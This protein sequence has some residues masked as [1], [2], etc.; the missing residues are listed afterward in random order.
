MKD[1]LFLAFFLILPN[2]IFAYDTTL[3]STCIGN[4]TSGCSLCSNSTCSRCQ[5]GYT[6]NSGSN[7]CSSNAC[8]I[9]NCAACSIN[10][11]Y[12]LKCSDKYSVFSASSSTCVQSCSL[13]NCAKCVAGSS[14]CLVCNSGYTVYSL[15]NQC[16]K[17]VISNCSVMFDF[18]NQ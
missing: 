9:A 8:L 11:S 10:G 2:Y 17:L 5:L 14:S 15:T 18:R 6:L 16:I 13:S 7:S 1:I 3:L 12:C 4:C